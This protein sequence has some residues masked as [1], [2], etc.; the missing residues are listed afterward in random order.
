MI[1]TSTRSVRSKKFEGNS[2][3]TWFEGNF[4][5]YEADKVKRLGEDALLPHR[6]QYKKMK[7]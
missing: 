6:I 4:T 5:D 7:R 3:V 2:Q 1:W